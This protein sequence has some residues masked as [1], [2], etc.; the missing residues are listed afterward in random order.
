MASATTVATNR[1]GGGIRTYHPGEGETRLADTVLQSF[2]GQ[3]S[4]SGSRKSLSRVSTSAACPVRLV[5]DGRL[6]L[7][8]ALRAGERVPLN[9]WI[10]GT[11]PNDDGIVVKLLFDVHFTA[12]LYNID[13]TVTVTAALTKAT[14]I[15][16]DEL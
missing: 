12:Y 1:R 6:R 15:Q 14:R 13:A 11:A 7:G 9:H 10:N 5:E 3:K 16:L 4:G 8:G 2:P